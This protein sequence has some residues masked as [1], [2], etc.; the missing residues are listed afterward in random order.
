MSQKHGVPVCDFCEK[1]DGPFVA[2]ASDYHICK[3]CAGL[4]A[5]IFGM[6]VALGDHAPL[7]AR[8][9]R[10]YDYLQGFEATHGYAPSFEEIASAFKYNSLATVHEHLA[11]LERKGWIKRDYNLSRSIRCLVNRQAAA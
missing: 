5:G 10:I 11:N 2:S 8:Q 6:T 4:A 1:T 3:R 7:T 9:S